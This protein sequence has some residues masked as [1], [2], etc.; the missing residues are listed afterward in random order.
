M[1]VN[2]YYFL[3]TLALI[4]SPVKLVASDVDACDEVI[5]E[6]MSHFAS[7]KS[8]TR[9][10]NRYYFSNHVA[11][12][13]GILVDELCAPKFLTHHDKEC[14]KMVEDALDR[15][16]VESIYVSRLRQVLGITSSW[17]ILSVRKNL[18]KNG[19]PTHRVDILYGDSKLSLNVNTTD[20]V[21]HTFGRL[22]IFEV[23]GKKVQEFLRVYRNF[24][25]IPLGKN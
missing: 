20:D 11:W 10:H 6:F 19:V 12:D 2:R 1:K 16:G 21:I 14:D 8:F 24:K 9:Q 15:S 22:E 5:S 18:T 13:A 3:I 4:F 17:K 23:N 7:D 25:F